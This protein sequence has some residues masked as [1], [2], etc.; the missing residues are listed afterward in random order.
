MTRYRDLIL[1][2]LREDRESA[3]NRLVTNGA[4][5]FDDYRYQCGVIAGL[6]AA[7]DQVADV[8]KHLTE[9]DYD[10]DAL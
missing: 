8:F 3:A 7:A 5:S 6:D 2:R 1:K 4:S 10:D 9:E